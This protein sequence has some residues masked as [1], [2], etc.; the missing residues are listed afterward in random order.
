[1]SAFALQIGAY[2]GISGDFLWPLLQAQPLLT[3]WRFEPEPRAYRRLAV[4]HAGDPRVRCFEKAVVPKAEGRGWSQLW[5]FK[6][7]VKCAKGTDWPGQASGL[8]RFGNEMREYPHLLEP[9][10]VQSVPIA[11]VCRTCPP[12]DVL[13]LDT[14]GMDG[15]LLLAFDWERH[16][17][18]V[19]YFEH[20]H[21]GDEELEEVGKLLKGMG[22]KLAALEHDMLC[23]RE[24]A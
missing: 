4:L 20:K 7:G 24:G 5:R 6:E 2:D 10:L 9:I 14:E 16:K 11:T 12:I 22:Y 1:M 15:K 23:V 13:V 18:R 17:P 3:A 8:L 19:V 21:L